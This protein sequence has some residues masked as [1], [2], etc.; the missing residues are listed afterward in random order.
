MYL[1]NNGFIYD[2]VNSSAYGLRFL[3][4]N[5]TAFNQVVGSLGYQNVFLRNSKRNVVGGVNYAESAPEID[6]EIISEQPI[7]AQSLRE[8]ENWLFCQNGYKK[9]Y[10]DPMCR[11]EGES[12]DPYDSNDTHNGEYERAENAVNASFDNT[13]IYPYIRCVFINPVEIRYASGVHGWGCTMVCDAP[14]ATLDEVKYEIESDEM[15]EYVGAVGYKQFVVNVDT[16]L[17]DYTYPVIQF[18]VTDSGDIYWNNSSDKIDG[19]SRPLIV[20]EYAHTAPV[21]FSMYC[22]SRINRLATS[23]A[24]D[25]VSLYDYIRMRNF[26][27][28]VRGENTIV[29]S[30]NVSKVTIEWHNRR[31]FL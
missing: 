9:L 10:I 13:K 31:W 17:H 7:S 30:D 16:D 4:I 29:V 3:E 11:D 22:N 19:V 28:L 20:S 1:S 8:I 25:G 2:G 23:T 21:S 14:Y 26:P 24:D 15:E 6:V 12:V 5:T 27:R 18:D